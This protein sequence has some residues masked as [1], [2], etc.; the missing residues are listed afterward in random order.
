MSEVRDL[1][2]KIVPMSLENEK[3]GEFNTLYKLMVEAYARLPFHLG[4][5]ALPLNPKEITEERLF[6]YTDKMT[7]GLSDEQKK[8][9]QKLYSD[10]IMQIKLI[11]QFFEKF[12]DA[13][14]EVDDNINKPKEQRISCINKVEAIRAV[15]KIDVSAENR[16]KNN[17]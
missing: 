16:H 17:I 5:E 3:I 15:S 6:S 7:K 2:K 4:K 13:E 11:R 14:F 1:S 9:W 8:V 10:A 12:P